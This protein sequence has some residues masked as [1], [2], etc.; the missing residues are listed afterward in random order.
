MAKLRKYSYRKR[1]F[2][3]P[4]RKEHDSYISVVCESSGDGSYACGNNLVTI[5]D[6]R[7]IIQLEFPLSYSGARRQSLSKIN[8][9]LEVLG[10]FR[11]A[12]SQES[13]LIAEDQ[14]RERRR[15]VKFAKK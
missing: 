2:L 13:Q 9:L 8:L 11:D 4:A 14:K 7:R 15:V 12:L 10:G 6:C 5:A 3:N 1:R